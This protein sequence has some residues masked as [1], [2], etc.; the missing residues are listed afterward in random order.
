[1]VL[2]VILGNKIFRLQAFERCSQSFVVFFVVV[3][4][5]KGVKSEVA[6]RPNH[7]LVTRPLSIAENKR[8]N[9]QHNHG[10]IGLEQVE[11][12]GYTV[13]QAA[14]RATNTDYDGARTRG[15]KASALHAL[16]R[17][18]DACTNGLVQLQNYRD[19]TC[20]CD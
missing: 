7:F 2:Y 17:S 12:A 18:A 11:M 1:M 3:S 16:E 9:V 10:L 15:E 20:T 19:N 14:P 8:V 13:K 5:S 4:Y 6:K